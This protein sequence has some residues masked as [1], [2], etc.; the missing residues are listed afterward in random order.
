MSAVW[1][2]LGLLMLNT[3]AGT[4]G[5]EACFRRA[6]E[7][8]FLL[9][10]VSDA[11]GGTAAEWA[12]S[13]WLPMVWEPALVKSGIYPHMRFSAMKTKILTALAAQD[14][15]VLVASACSSYSDN[16]EPAPPAPPTSPVTT[17]DDTAATTIPSTPADLPPS[18]YQT[19]YF[20][21]RQTLSPLLADVP[22]T[23][24]S[25]PPNL[26]NLVV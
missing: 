17:D 16:S 25:H 10:E 5:F 2:P 24:N 1:I 21:S 4:L 23:S 3:L 14:V 18:N 11:G 13:G 22:Q 15:S 8:P 19:L 12:A 6:E 9:G 26:I 7:T 20:P